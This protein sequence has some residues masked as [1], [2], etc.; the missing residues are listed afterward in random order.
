MNLNT[1]SFYR[2]R[3]EKLEHLEYAQFLVALDGELS[4]YT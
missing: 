2:I 3:I 1:H 4:T